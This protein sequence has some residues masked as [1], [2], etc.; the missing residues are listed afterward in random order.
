MNAL[1]LQCELQ[2]TAGRLYMDIYL[3]GGSKEYLTKAKKA[4]QQVRY[5]TA[6]FSVFFF[7]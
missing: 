6:L 2:L 4:F 1:D 5:F 7:I 3:S